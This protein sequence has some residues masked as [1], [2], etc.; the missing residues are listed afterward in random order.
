MKFF[1]ANSDEDYESCRKLMDE[2]EVEETTSL[3]F[4]TIL[5]RD[6][7]DNVV[8]FLGS[9]YQDQMLFAGPLV[10]KKRKPRTAMALCENYD[11]ACRSMGLTGYLMYTKDGTFMAEGIKR[12][13]LPGFEPYAREGNITFYIRRL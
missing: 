2:E 10:V 3:Q 7:D 5:A 6:D 12:Y 13:N 8:G 4:P 9:F 11:Q 1:I